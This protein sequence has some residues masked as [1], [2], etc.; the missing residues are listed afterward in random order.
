VFLNKDG[1]Q[2]NDISSDDLVIQPP[3]PPPPPPWL[4]ELG[5][6]QHHKML[7]EELEMLDDAI[8]TACQKLIGDHNANIDSLQ[9]TQVYLTP[10]GLTY[11]PQEAIQLHHTGSTHWIGSTSLGGGVGVFDSMVSLPNGVV[12]LQ[13]RQVYAVPDDKQLKVTRHC[14]PYNSKQT[15]CSAAIMRLPMQSSWHSVVVRPN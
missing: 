3:N 4:A 15:A 6:N 9:S 14:Y 10:Q 1:K 2:V 8:I 7:L 13:L 11:A 12:C 5:L